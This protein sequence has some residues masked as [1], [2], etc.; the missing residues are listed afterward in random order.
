M[1]DMT[2][3][4]RVR[5]VEETLSWAE[6]MYGFKVEKQSTSSYIITNR[7]ANE[8]WVMKLD[9]RL[10]KVRRLLHANHTYARTD[11]EIQSEYH[12]HNE[13]PESDV[14][15]LCLYLYNHGLKRRKLDSAAAARRSM[16]FSSVA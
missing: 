9:K 12:V 6:L 2:R 10:S 16:L 8:R 11:Q 1:T 4:M 3:E 7:Q 5:E 15:K 13:L 14:K